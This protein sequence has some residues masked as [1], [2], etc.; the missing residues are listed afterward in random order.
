MNEEYSPLFQQFINHPKLN[1]MANIMVKNKYKTFF[2][3][4]PG[5]SDGRHT[6]GKIITFLKKQH[7]VIME[8]KSITTSL[9]NTINLSGNHLIYARTSCSD[10]FHPM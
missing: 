6:H 9:N 4:N 3:W 5:L 2:T 10:Q 7:N 1:L 8:Y